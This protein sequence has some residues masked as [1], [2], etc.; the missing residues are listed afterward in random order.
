MSATFNLS[1]DQ[2][3]ETPEHIFELGCDTFDFTPEIDVR[4]FS[5][6]NQGVIP[7]KVTDEDSVVIIVSYNMLHK[8]INR[9]KEP[10]WFRIVCEEAHNIR[11]R[12]RRPLGASSVFEH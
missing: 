10:F 8:N 5:S 1:N 6:D 2:Y 7:E 3:W 9:F 11:R 4:I 12:I